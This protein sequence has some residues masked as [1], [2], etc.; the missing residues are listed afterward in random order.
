MGEAG[1]VQEF[2]HNADDAE[3]HYETD[4]RVIL[5]DLDH[6]GPDLTLEKQVI[7]RI[8]KT[9]TFIG[10][11][12]QRDLRGGREEPLRC[13]LLNEFLGAL[14]KRLERVGT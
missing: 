2:Q 3:G 6:D 12:R 9:Q 13:D 8:W 1:E 5:G 11:F 14:L 4:M 7:V 10:Y